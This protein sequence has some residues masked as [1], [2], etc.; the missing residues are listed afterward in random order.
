MKLPLNCDAEYQ[1][2]FLSPEESANL[3]RQIFQDYSIDQLKLEIPLE[4]GITYSDYGKLMFLDR[5]LYEGGK[6]PEAVWGK[7]AIWTDQLMII[8]ERVEAFA[9]TTFQTCVCIYYPDGNSG[10]D[11]HSDY[12]AFGDTTI[13]PS[14]SVG[15]ERTFCLREKSSQ[16]VFSINLENGSIFRV[17][18]MNLARI[19]NCWSRCWS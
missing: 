6:F 19:I 18:L 13:I 11:F 9:K 3:Y 1:S 2:G 15:E 7:T 5:D 16:E 4:E 8:K 17:S 10:V 12:I 14:I